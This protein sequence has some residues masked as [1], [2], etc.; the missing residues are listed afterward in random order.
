MGEETRVR[1]DFP[2]D[3]LQ[4]LEI[5]MTRIS[6]KRENNTLRCVD[7]HSCKKNWIHT[8]KTYLNL[9]Y[10]Q[11]NNNSYLNFVIKTWL[12]QS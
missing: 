5:R 3:F 8:T 7:M 6:G 2:D 4:F 10:C 1:I 9:H 11:K 12:R